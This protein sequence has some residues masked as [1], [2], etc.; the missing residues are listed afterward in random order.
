MIRFGVNLPNHPGGDACR[1]GVGGDVLGDHGPGPDD[2]A[3]PDMYPRN[4]R[5]AGADPDV[6]PGDDGGGV[7]GGSKS[8]FMVVSTTLL[9]KKVPSPRVMPP[10]SWKWQPVLIKTPLPTVVFLPQLV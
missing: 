2:G 7:G 3:V 4:H 9:P 1:D 5:N 6:L 10:W 8:W